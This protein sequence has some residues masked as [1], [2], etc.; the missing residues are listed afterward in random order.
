MKCP[1]CKKKIDRVVVTS[2]CWQYGDLV[3]AKDSTLTTPRFL[4]EEYGSIEEIYETISI[5]CPECDGDIEEYVR[6]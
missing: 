4:I 2:K 5:T 6:Q 3:E 1:K